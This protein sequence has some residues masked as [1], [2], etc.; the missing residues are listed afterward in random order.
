M[1]CEASFVVVIGGANIDIHGKSA[2]T[3]RAHDSNPGSV[4]LSAGGVARNVAENLA[5]LGVDTRLV[6][7]VGDDYHGK[8]L[9][10]LS[11]EAGINLQHV[12][13]IAGAPTSTYLSVLDAAGEMQVAIS[14]MSIIDRLTADR[15]R[16]LEG[17]LGEAA[18]LILDTNLSDGALAWLA[19]CCADKPLF[20]DTV[21]TAKAPR[22]APYLA[23]I[24][25]LKMS[26]LEATAL[27]G[28]EAG[29]RT[30]LAKIA[31]DLHAAGVTRVFI[32]LGERGVFYSTGDARGT[33]KLERGQRK[34]HNAGG[35]GDAFLAGL[36]YAWLEDW[37][38]A[39]TLPFA[40]AAAALTVSDAATNNPGLSLEAIEEA[41]E[42]RNA[43]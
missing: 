42:K 3:L 31:A 20:V 26:A 39:D 18:L 10:R 14:D 2:E 40:L 28:R 33:T 43:G 5:R 41:L 11:R 6:S 29:S 24:H 25:T 9:M 7:A 4:R 13:E 36:G 21:S 27:T 30:Q 37:S 19:S 35:A 22:I 32:T 23:A 1:L 15:L 16:P 38:L 12:Q 34:V 8:L 17:M